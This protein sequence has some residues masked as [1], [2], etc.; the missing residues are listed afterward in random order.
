MSLELIRAAFKA[1][2]PTTHK[3]VFVALCDNAD[4]LGECFPSVSLLMEKT[5]LSERSVRNSLTWLE[6]AGFLSR[7]GRKGRSNYFYI[8]RPAG[9]QKPVNQAIKSGATP[10]PDAPL[11]LHHVHPTPAAGAPP[12]LH[13]V[14]PTPARGAPITTNEP[15]IEPSVNHI[16][17]DAKQIDKSVVFAIELRKR[18]VQCQSANPVLHELARQG[19]ELPTLMAACDQAE[20]SKGKNGYTLGYVV[21]ILRRWAEQARSMQVQGAQRPQAVPKAGRNEAR[22]AFSQQIREMAGYGTVDR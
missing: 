7:R 13:V 19:V 12:P 11:P 4:D 10:A 6:Q 1:G 5:S 17:T 2:M 8:E 20:Q 18:G 22:A 14:H 3:F 15:S 16:H 21:G 9:W